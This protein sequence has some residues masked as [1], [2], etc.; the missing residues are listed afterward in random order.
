MNKLYWIVAEKGDQTVYEGRFIGRSRGEA[1]KHLKA[2]LGRSNLTGLV[3]SITEIPVPLIREI[4]AEILAGRDGMTAD[5]VPLP[6]PSPALPAEPE[7]P[8]RF[9]AFVKRLGKRGVS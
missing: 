6:A 4:V 3:F 1:L 7:Q 2:Q 8:I 9:E 5:S